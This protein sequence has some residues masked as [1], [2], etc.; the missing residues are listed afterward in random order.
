MVLPVHHH[1]CEG[2]GDLN[3]DVCDDDGDNMTL[4]MIIVNNGDVKQ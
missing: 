3:N 2:H 4:L 1:H